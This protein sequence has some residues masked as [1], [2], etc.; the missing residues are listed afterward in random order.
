MFSTSRKL[1][2]N[3][4][5]TSID[6]EMKKLQKEVNVTWHGKWKLIKAALV[7]KKKNLENI[8]MRWLSP[9]MAFINR[10]R[11]GENQLFIHIILSFTLLILQFLETKVNWSFSVFIFTV[12]YVEN[13]NLFDF[14][15]FAIISAQW[16]WFFFCLVKWWKKKKNT[17]YSC[18]S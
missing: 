2:V 13:K 3:K 8:C 1:G 17:E 9:P 11:V 5:Y 4:Y 14:N 15:G 7:E 12:N 16:S 18:R 10:K 6:E